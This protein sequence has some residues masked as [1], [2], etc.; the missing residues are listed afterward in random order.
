MKWPDV[1][2]PNPAVVV[3]RW[4][5]S[6]SQRSSC[7]K[8]AKSQ[9][10]KVVIKSWPNIAVKDKYLGSVSQS[11]NVCISILVRKS[12]EALWEFF[13][14]ICHYL[15]G[16]W[17]CRCSHQAGRSSSPGTR[18]SCSLRQTAT[19]LIQRQAEQSAAG[20]EQKAG[21]QTRGKLVCLPPSRDG[22]TPSLLL[23][24]SDCSSL[25]SDLHN[26]HFAH[27]TFWCLSSS[28][29]RQPKDT[30]YICEA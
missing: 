25:L 16:C 20:E 15:P 26:L 29:D 8:W 9:T 11:T 22:K 21:N 28:C 23:N 14:L 18:T 13:F 12:P 7:I 17:H 24:S 19:S 2:S 1:N 5:S 30:S 6:R 27:T 3:S 10:T 4:A